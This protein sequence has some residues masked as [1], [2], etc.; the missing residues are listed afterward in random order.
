[1]FFSIDFLSTFPA[2]FLPSDEQ[3]TCR[4]ALFFPFDACRHLPRSKPLR[5]PKAQLFL[6]LVRDKKIAHQSMITRMGQKVKGNRVLMCNRIHTSCKAFAGLGV[7]RHSVFVI[8]H[9]SL[10]YRHAAKREDE[11]TSPFLAGSSPIEIERY[12]RFPGDL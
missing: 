7:I 10:G 2:D 9:S 1:V 12:F 4:W 5:T 8:R 11:M 6:Q 3:K